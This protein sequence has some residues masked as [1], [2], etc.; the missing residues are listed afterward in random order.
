MSLPSR[1][2]FGLALA[3][4]V[5]L[6]CSPPPDPPMSD[7][8]EPSSG[9]ATPASDTIRGTVIYRERM[10]PPPGAV[11]TVVLEDVSRADAPAD[12]LARQ[13][14]PLTSGPPYAFS[15]A[16]ESGVIQERR[17]YTLRAR[18]QEGER[19]LWTSTENI[20]PFDRP[21]DTPIEILLTRVGGGGSPR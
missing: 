3:A 8:A 6:S 17:R 5:T 16:Y 2:P 19:L 7:S 1:R 14:I 12:V 13:E 21:D 11:L 15:L 4:L 20:P 18:I 9:A 10:M